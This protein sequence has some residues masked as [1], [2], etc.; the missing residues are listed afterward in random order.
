MG[1]RSTRNIRVSGPGAFVV[2]K[3]LAFKTRGL[4]KD[5]Y[6]LFNVE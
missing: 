3:A 4:A 2:L 5:A 6:D 1:E